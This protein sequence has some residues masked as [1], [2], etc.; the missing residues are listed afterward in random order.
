MRAKTIA[1]VLGIVL[2][3]VVFLAYTSFNQTPQVL[4]SS[5]STRSSNNST[6]TVSNNSG[7]VTTLE[8]LMAGKFPTASD[9]DGT[10]GVTVTVRNLNVLY[11]RTE[12]DGDWHVGVTDGTVTIFITEITPFYQKAE[13]MPPV[14]SSI[15]ERGVPYCDTVHETES[16]H[17]NTCWEIHPVTAWQLSSSNAGASVTK[18]Q[19]T[20]RG[21]NVVIS[22][23]QNPIPRGSTQT[24]TVQVRD[25]DGPV[26]GATASIEVDYASGYTVDNFSCTT[27]PDGTCSISWDIGPTTT[28]GTFAVI[29]GVGGENFNSSFSVTD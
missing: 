20:G 14:G 6:L 21:L 1:I 23:D 26:H 10:G 17:D 29:V 19:I 5:T 13:G 2:L 9:K 16:W 28:P 3:G 22:Y 25:S 18:S 7:L 24:I 15:D 4:T 11:V 27:A 8:D 12:S